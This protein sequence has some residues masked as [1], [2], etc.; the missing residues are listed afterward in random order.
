MRPLDLDV[1]SYDCSAYYYRGRR[2]NDDVRN[3]V[4]H[5]RF[6]AIR[7]QCRDPVT[8]NGP[9]RDRGVGVAPDGIAKKASVDLAEGAAGGR[10]RRTVNILP[11][12][13]GLWSG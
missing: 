3:D 8:V 13:R 7:A 11:S 2:W 5:R 6:R 12:N 10:I 1:S 9:V 4:R